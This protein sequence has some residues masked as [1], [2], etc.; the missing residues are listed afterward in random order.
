MFIFKVF[1]YSLKFYNRLKINPTFLSQKLFGKRGAKWVND[2]KYIYRNSSHTNNLE[3]ME[4]KKHFFLKNIIVFLVKKDLLLKNFWKLDLYHSEICIP[5]TLLVILFWCS[6]SITANFC[7]SS[8]ASSKSI[9]SEVVMHNPVLGSSTVYWYSKEASFFLSP[10]TVPGVLIFWKSPIR[11]F[12]QVSS[13]NFIV[14]PV[15][16]RLCLRCLTFLWA[17]PSE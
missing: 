12:E 7:N 10:T 13:A 14:S 11:A 3:M 1:L 16:P 15:L 2:L 6:A 17:A 8:S 5:S 4:K 9:A